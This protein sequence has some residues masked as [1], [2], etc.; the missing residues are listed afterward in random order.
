MSAPANH[1]EPV[2]LLADLREL[3]LPAFAEHYS[4]VAD[5]AQRSHRGHADYLADLAHLEVTGRLERRI[6][7]RRG[8]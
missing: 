7:R 4:R 1:T 6:T 5:E 3:K 8:N 2:H